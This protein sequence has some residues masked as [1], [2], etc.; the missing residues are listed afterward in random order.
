MVGVLPIGKGPHDKIEQ[1]TFFWSLPPNGYQQWQQNGMTAW[2]NSVQ[3]YWPE[4][5]DLLEQFH[6]PEQLIHA[7]YSDIIL[8][9]WHQD[10]MVIIGDA[11]H[12]SSPQLGQGANLALCDAVILAAN[13]RH[14][15]SLA[16]ALKAYSAQRKSHV[17]FYQ[18]ASRWLTPFFQS[19]SKVYPWLRDLLFAPMGRNRWLRQQMLKTLSGVKTGPFSELE[20]KQ[21]Y[22]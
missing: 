17:R 6:L 12:N 21:L 16:S 7:Q 14:H 15:D 2:K 20:P 11:G 19:D 18:F 3:S 10:N 5:T 13:I 8:K 9:Q 4:L 1:S 22:R